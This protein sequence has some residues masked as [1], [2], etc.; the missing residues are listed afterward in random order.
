MFVLF[1]VLPDGHPRHRSTARLGRIVMSRPDL[2]TVWQAEE[3]VSGV[4]EA[5]R[6]T[7]GEI[8]ACGADVRVENGVTAKHVV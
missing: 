4:I 3:L 8:T 5:A 1:L 2:H 6:T 7:A